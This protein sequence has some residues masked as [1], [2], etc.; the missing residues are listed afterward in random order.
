MVNHIH[1]RTDGPPR[2][3]HITNYYHDSSGGVKSNYDKLLHAAER[4]KRRI[5]LIV[6]GEKNHVEQVNEYGRIYFVAAP[7]A[8][9]ID[10]RYRVILPYHYLFTDSAVRR[11]LLD[12]KPDFIEIYD[13]YALTFLAG[14][15][16]MGYF[17]KLGRPMFI[18]FTGE[19]FDT[20]FKTFVVGGRVGGWFSRRT[21]ANFNLPMFDCYVANSSFV[22]NELLLSFRK[23]NN[24]RRW[25]W[26]H[27]RCGRFFKALREP[28][29][30]R[31]AI[32]PRGVNLSE[33]TPERRSA[34]TRER[35]CKEAGVPLDATLVLS[36]TRLS[37]EKNI[38][39]LPRIMEKLAQDGSRDFRLLIAGAGPEEK[40]LRTKARRFNGKMVLIGHLDKN[41]LAE[42]YANCDVFIH[43]NPREPFGNVGLEA[44]ASGA[45]CVMPHSGGVLTYANHGNA[46]LVE[47]RADEFAAAIHEASTNE[48]LR[49]SKIANAL[50]M[51]FHNSEDAAIDNLLATYDRMYGDFVNR[52]I[53]NME[54][55]QQ[56]KLS[57]KEI[58]RQA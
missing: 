52:D 42:H 58:H 17:R 57:G 5:S 8:P 7:Q 19:R 41:S 31:L 55:T 34:E 13:N 3:V 10:H 27:E 53:K 44:M 46:W 2:S 43:P 30:E 22:A 11:V 26:F 24:P 56:A 32:C 1:S 33:F 36:A 51:A 35:I 28:I 23:A 40:Y 25:E 14:M 15:T 39:L 21:L 38:K 4:H 47:A 45:A 29:E 54:A 48:L 6:P 50:D 9:F 49:R 16:R 12:E 37:Q 20:I 18:Y